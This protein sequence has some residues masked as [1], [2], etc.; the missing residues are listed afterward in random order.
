MWPDIRSSAIL[1]AGPGD[2]VIAEDPA[3]L[4][5]LETAGM[6]ARHPSAV[7]ITGET[8]SGKELVARFVHQYSSRNARPW[9]DVNCA[10]LPEHLV[11]SE[12]FGYE[13]GAFS[14]ADS[15]KPGLFELANGGTLFLDEIG[16]IDPRV[17]VK[18]LR[19]LD[20]VP[21]YRLG[22]SRKVNVDVRV[23]AATNRDLEAAVYSGTFRRDLFHRIS[24]F[25]IAVPPLR[26]R[27]LDIVALATHFL[28]QLHPG[29]S[30]TDD[31][32]ELLMQQEWLGN[33]RELR[34]LVMKL[35][36]VVSKAEISD[37]DVRPL[38][39]SGSRAVISHSPRPLPSITTLDEL[40]RMMI[41]RTLEATGGNQSRA[42]QRLGIPRRTFCRKLN[43]YRIALG[44]RNASSITTSPLTGTC[45]AELSV[46]VTVTTLDGRSFLA[47]ATNLSTGGLGLK[48]I[49]APLAVSDHVT[50]NLTLPGLARALAA[51]ATVV[52]WRPDG[53]AGTRFTQ[54]T[55]ATS[56]VLQDW[57]ASALQHQLPPDGCVGGR[58]RL[59]PKC[60]QPT[61]KRQTRLRCNPRRNLAAIHKTP[62][63]ANASVPGSG[64]GR[65]GSNAV[66]DRSTYG[67]LLPP[68]MLR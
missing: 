49:D 27:P 32:L 25:H 63:A 20:S 15:T 42:A 65:S 55:P 62:G 45:R 19:V 28:A 12:L 38:L 40:E 10:A 17:Q 48:N 1:D 3:M 6:I 23:I 67:P 61:L 43:E 9:V 2:I 8:G 47:E 50:L 34:N 11:E 16:E 64:T 52:W 46:P 54:L 14:G 4:A 7:L 44:R 68:S 57:V 51:Q 35:G 29:K 66:T 26:Q 21:Y 22:G 56:A 24:E 36:A 58:R 39:G 18:L 53:S 13:K 60:N 30:I 59:P 37:H 33:V 41:L 5:V 31:A